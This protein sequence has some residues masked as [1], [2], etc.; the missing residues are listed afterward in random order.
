MYRTQWPNPKE[1]DQLNQLFKF[2]YTG[3]EQ[4]WEIEFADPNRIN[5]FISAYDSSD[6]TASQK[7]AVMDLIIASYDELLVKVPEEKST[8]KKIAALLRENRAIHEGSL[9][10]WSCPGAENSDEMFEVTE[11]IRVIRS[12]SF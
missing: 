10:Y 5:E 6:L 4:D 12:E 1:L 8:W 9:E 3:Y 7:L 11:R 2:P